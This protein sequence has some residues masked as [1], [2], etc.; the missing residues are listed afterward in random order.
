MNTYGTDPTDT[1]TD[2]DGF[3]DADEQDFWGANWNT[4]YDGDGITNNLLDPDSDND[5]LLDGPEVYTYG[6]NPAVQDT[7]GDGFWDG[8]EAS[9]GF[10]PT[11]PGDYCRIVMNEVLYDPAGYGDADYEFVELFNPHNFSIDISGF[12][13]QT[14]GQVFPYAEYTVPEEISIPAHSYFLIGGSSV[15]DIHGYAPDLT[16]SNLNMQNGDYTY[17]EGGYLVSSPTDGVRLT[18]PYEKVLDTVL[19]DV[20]NSNNLP[21]DDANPGQEFVPDTD[22]NS[23]WSIGRTAAGEDANLAADWAHEYTPSPASSVYSR[24][25]FDLDGDVDGDDR[26]R[27]NS[28]WGTD[29]VLTDINFDGTVDEKDLGILINDLDDTS[30]DT[31]GDGISDYDEVNHDGDPGYN[32]YDPVTNPSGTDPDINEADTDGDGFGDYIEVYAGSNPADPGDGPSIIR[33]NCQP[34]DSSV[35]ASYMMDDGT[36]YGAKFYGW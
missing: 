12:L 11:N 27:L 7:D 3:E 21:G 6:T 18:T 17:E 26:D 15:T 36:P 25:D 24:C 8:W 16:A 34:A 30:V 1:D 9:N 29:T 28:D 32:P 20:P 2:D 23:G 10:S 35:P 19:Y 4:N 31:D 14:A 33:I 22:D 13:I 5:N